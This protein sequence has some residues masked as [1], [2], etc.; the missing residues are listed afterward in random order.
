MN[1][2]RIKSAIKR[3]TKFA[4]RVF[5]SKKAQVAKQE[6]PS[7]EDI[8]SVVLN[9]PSLSPSYAAKSPVIMVK[10]DCLLKSE[11]QGPRR[12]PVLK[13][14]SV[15]SLVVSSPSDNLVSPTVA[16]IA[17]YPTPSTA[18]IS[19]DEVSDVVQVS[20]SA[21]QFESTQS[22]RSSLEHE[23]KEADAKRAKNSPTEAPAVVNVTE[24]RKK[25]IDEAIKEVAA[26]GT[27]Q[28]IQQE[29]ELAFQR[30]KKTLEEVEKN[31]ALRVAKHV[32]RGQH[33]NFTDGIEKAKVMS[34]EEYNATRRIQQQKQ[35][36][37]CN[38]NKQ[39]LNQVLTSN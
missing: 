23:V 16:L 39:Q 4:K 38:C 33:I 21:N 10:Q 27:S 13:S 22:R 19:A 26:V 3:V 25:E 36:A 14:A 12:M 17:E 9:R 24:Q 18:V 15:S 5:G 34:I 20:G 32:R 2:L 1:A 37:L 29:I 7:F 31:Q 11:V 6:Q 8:M 35:C 30:L 28:D